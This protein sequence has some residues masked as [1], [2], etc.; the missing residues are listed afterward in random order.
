M[1]LAEF[2][3]S[4]VASGV[5]GGAAAPFLAYLESKWAW[6]SKAEPWVRRLLAWVVSCGLGVLPYLIQVVMQY[7]P[8]PVDWR[9]WVEKLFVVAFVAITANQG[10]HIATKPKRE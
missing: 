6:L 8:V 9:E 3:V 10:A 5:L 7:E 4:L 2:L 1:N